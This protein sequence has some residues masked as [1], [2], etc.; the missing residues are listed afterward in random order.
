MKIA[1]AQINS[2]LGAF[3]A[4]RKK[5]EAF[6]KKAEKH[7]C[8]LIIFPESALFGYHPVDLL[9]RPSIVDAQLRELKKLQK[10]IPKNLKVLVGAI[11]HN[12]K[13]NGK[14]FLNAAVLLSKNKSPKI[15]AKEL[16]PT[17]DVFDEGRHIQPG[18]L[19][20]N[21]FSFKGKKILVTI[22]EDI[23]AWTLPGQ[24]HS[25]YAQNPLLKIK[26]GN[27]D[28]VVNLSASPFTDKK[29]KWRQF[30][31]SK[32][33]THFKAPLIYVNMVGAQDEI[34][35]DG[36]SLFTSKK[37]QLL[38][39]CERFQE[40][41]QVI[42]PFSSPVPQ[43]RHQP[44]VHHL[45]KDAILLGISDFLKKTGLS[46]VHLGLSGGLDSALVACLATEALGPQK[47]TA[48]ALPGPYSSSQSLR[49]ARKLAKNLKI[50]FLK[51]EI[52]ST[53]KHL[54]AVLEKTLGSIPF[55]TVQE[56]L[57]A[58]L[59]A[60]CLMA[61]ANK[62]NSLLLNTSNKSEMATGYTTLYGDL[63]GGLCPIGDLL[64]TE[65]KQ[66]AKTIY[67]HV[68]P[69]E[70]ISRPPS[71]ELRPHQ[72]DTDSLPPYPIL[73][74]IVEKLVENYKGTHTSTGR[75]VLKMLMKSEFKRWQAPPIL[76]ISNHAF[77]RGR[78]FPIASKAIF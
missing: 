58:R 18:D 14:P 35:F 62:N 13:S 52:T 36:A 73:D 32:T 27:V 28:L 75:Q 51:I 39:Q 48:F 5:I 31:T 57:Q 60:L 38:Q 40:D 10:K 7:S 11:T 12:P 68:I 63:C 49:L 61:Y 72:K 3:E 17:Y 45:R 43:K 19:S 50:S 76:K 66:M 29:M 24:K 74:P 71:A 70:I 69:Q 53:Y 46:Q 23:W 34:I 41:F 22:C 78:R 1:I 15:F 4:N 6:C 2:F 64:K 20:K 25:N 9:E 47:V 59:R 56:N 42:E 16:L 8:D 26:P 33:A 44:N 65:V 37:G 54:L 30:V 67:A 21:I 77:G 55:G